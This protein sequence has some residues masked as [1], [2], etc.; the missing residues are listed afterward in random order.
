MR[1][2]TAAFLEKRKPEFKGQVACEGRISRRRRWPTPPRSAS[3]SSSRASTRP[4]PAASATPRT[5]AL[6]EAGRDR[7]PGARRCRARSRSRRRR[8]PP[9]ETGRFDAIVCLGCIIRGETPH[10]EY[11]ASAVAHGITEA[12]GDTGI[13]MAFGVLTTD[14]G[15]AGDGAR[16]ARA[17]QQGPGSGG[18]RRSR[19]PCCSARSAATGVENRVDV[20]VRAAALR[21]GE[22]CRTAAR[23]PPRARGR[24]ADALSDGSRPRVG[25]RSGPHLLAGR[26]A[27]PS[28]ED[29]HADAV[30]EVVVDEHG[31]DVRQRP[32][33]RH[34]RPRRRDRRAD[35][36]RT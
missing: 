2:G 6:N 35:R 15:G 3:P 30:P 12:A 13:P 9:A 23:A 29:E 25:A 33:R 4:S 20:R 16:R 28:P 5:A 21:R 18:G 11:I 17:R 31:A 14:T 34:D 7:R 19:W 10:F 27:P 32:G 1:E 22:S 24:A 36:R 8:A 26:D